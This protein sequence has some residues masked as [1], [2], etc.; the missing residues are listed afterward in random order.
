VEPYGVLFTNGDNDTF[1]LWYLQET[2]GIR[3]DVTVIVM[4]YLNTQWYARQLRDLTQ[5][6][7]PGVSPDRDPTRIICQRPYDPAGG[8]DFYRP[9]VTQGDQPGV[10]VATREGGAPTGSILPLSDAEIAD[11]T[12]TP[13]FRLP[14]ARS[15]RAHNLE[16]VL[17]QNT[18]M[19]PADFFMA[20]IIQSALDNRPIYFAMTTQAYEELNLRPYLIR[21][22]VALK[23]NDGPVEPD[24]ERGIYEVPSSGL[25]G[26]IGP[27][28]DMP[29]TETLLTDV[30]MHRGGIPEEWGHWVDIATEGIPA[31]YGYSHMGMALVYEAHGRV[32]DA[33]RHMLRGNQWLDLANKRYTA[34]SAP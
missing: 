3:R 8:P 15:F 19:V 20:Q 21:Q 12:S 25:T 28:I 30:F 23:L 11:V 4:S 9:Y 29:R 2:E 31:Y 10:R 14:E 5:P 22:G 34:A 27:Y 6:C 33:Q 24:S 17:P 18:V 32:N 26:I 7:E 1:P 16:T 13:P